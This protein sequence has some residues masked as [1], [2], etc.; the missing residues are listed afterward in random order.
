MIHKEWISL[1]INAACTMR[2][3][4][5]V[6]KD[7]LD[8]SSAVIDLDAASAVG[9]LSQ[10]FE[11]AFVDFLDFPNK[12]MLCELK[13]IYDQITLQLENSAFSYLVNPKRLL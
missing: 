9:F 3:R 1:S 6:F 11:I 4:V 8:N 7:Y 5:M 2:R 10:I 12:A 13:S